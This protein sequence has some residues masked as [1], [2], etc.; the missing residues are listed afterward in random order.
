MYFPPMML[1]ERTGTPGMWPANFH[2]A[3][4]RAQ[5]QAVLGDATSPGLRLGAILVRLVIQS[6]GDLFVIADAAA[7]A[8]DRRDEAD[9]RCRCLIGAGLRKNVVDFAD[10][11]LFGRRIEP[12]AVIVA[13][14]VLNC[15]L[16]FAQIR[17]RIGI[18]DGDENA[19]AEIEAERGNVTYEKAVLSLV[20]F[21]E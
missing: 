14:D 15:P 7:E 8:G 17:F 5:Q 16:V 6:S 12:C 3:R 13:G 18:G 19:V 11:T 2:A 20:D 10:L 4:Y 1:V 21:V 9:L